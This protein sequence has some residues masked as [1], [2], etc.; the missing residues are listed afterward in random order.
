MNVHG[1]QGGEADFDAHARI[2]A[3]LDLL[4]AGP[5][6]EA[7]SRALLTGAAPEDVETL[8]P[9]A[10]ARL[11]EEAFAHL[12]A[13]PP[14]RHDVRV[15]NPEWPGA[16][17]ITVIEAANDDM[18]FLFDSVAGELADRNLELK[19]TSH[20][21][22]AVKRDASGAIES[23]SGDL[24]G[25]A[26]RGLPHESLIHLHIQPLES[27]EARAA[28]KQAL[29]RTLDDV[30][31]ATGDFIAMRDAV[32]GLAKAWPGAALPY[33]E[34][35]RD[36]AADFI[37]WLVGNNFIFLGVRRYRRAGDGLLEAETGLGVLRDPAVRE[38]AES[39]L[40]ADGAPAVPGDKPLLIAK[41]SLWS[42]VHRR[43]YMDFVGLTLHDADGAP[44][45]ELRII[46]LFTS[47][48]YT[49]SV[50]EIPYLRLKAEAVAARAGFERESHSGKALSTVLETYPRDDLFQ[51]DVDTLA[52]YALDILSLYD[53]PR[54]RVLPRPDLFGRF[55]SVLV[56]VPRERFDSALRERIGR[57]L[58]ATFDGRV[59]SFTPAFLADVPLTRVH[60][61]IGRSGGRVPAV[62]R[63]ELERAVADD[64]LSWSDR[65]RDALR[66][67][68]GAHD[69]LVLF[70]RY[71]SAFGAGYSAAYGV[72]TAVADI[73][74]LERL[75]ADRPIALDFYR[76]EDDLATRISLRLLS[77]GRPLP[78]SERVPMLENMGLKAINERTYR[79][80]PDRA[81]TSLAWIHDMT[82]ERCTGG[83]IEVSGAAERMEDL[84]T[85]VL[86]GEA[87]NDGFNALVLDTGL[88]WR[89]VA[90]ARALA[91]YLRQAGI[92]YSQDYLWATLVG[93]A[94]VAAHIVQLFHMRFDPRLDPAAQARAAREEPL[95]REIEAALAEVSSLDEDTIL[96]RFVNL[97]DAALRTT[98]YQV[99][100]DGRPKGAISIKY[101]SAKVEGLP[102]PRPLY[103]V[104]VYSPRVEGVHLRFGHVARGGLRWSDRPQDFRTEVLG[105]VKAQQV[106][107]AVIVPVGAK[108]GFVPKR[109]PSGGNR[110]AFMAEGIAAYKLF[111][112]SLLDITDN[113]KAGQL[114]YPPN[115]VRID[116]DDPYLVVAADKGTAT[117][118][119]T[120]NGISQE[121]GFWLDDAFASGG[122]VGYDHKA[123]GITARGAWEAVKRHFREID[124]D[125]Q[126]T[127]IQ[128]V[129]VGD[130]SGDVFGNGMLLSTVLKL[131]AAFDHRHIFLDPDP[132]PAAAFAERQRLFALP[133]S[134]WADYDAAL[135]SKGGGVFSRTAKSIPLS[136]EVRAVIGLEK[137]EATPNEVMNAILKAQVDL[138][139]FG[140][141]G[142]YVRAST[143]T[144]AQAGDRANDAIRIPAGDLRVKV[145]GEGANLGMTQRGRIEAARRGVRLNTDAIDN[146]AGVNTSD[147]EVNIKIALS[148]PVAEG[149]LSAP[150][151]AALLGTMTD[152]VAHLVL[153]NNYLQTLALSLAQRSGTEDM[154]F[155]QRLM[156]M[157]ELRGELDRAV[158]Y[159]P[160]DAE[161]QER[162]S[163]GEALT[164]PELAV[165]LAYAK[166]SL[167]AEMLT[168]D[169]PDDIYLADEL[170][171]YFP[172]ALQSRFPDAIQ[173]HR[174]RREIIATGLANAV[175]N[176]GGPATIAR[177]ADQS[178][179]DA[180]A[181]VR[182]FAA[183][184]DSFGLPALNAAIDALDS[185]IPGDMQLRLYAE[186]QN[187]SLARTIWF[188]RNVSLQSGIGPVVARYRT[189]IEALAEVLDDSLPE[190]W[191]A[192][193]DRKAAEFTDAG[194]PAPLAL[195]IAGLRPLAAGTDIALLSQTTGRSVPEAARTFFAAGLYFGVDSVL[196]AAGSILAPDYYDRL[197]MDRALGQ[198]E[199][200][201]R[202][203]SV[204]MLNGPA[205]GTEAVEAWVAGRRKEVERTRA[206]VQDIV[207]SGLTLSKLT[208]AAS[209]LSDIARA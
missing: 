176:Q 25:A 146:S 186:V 39:T 1:V 196:S 12:A 43:A 177:I 129:G 123:M 144:D 24:H 181:I 77:Y 52:T 149:V 58:A 93:H 82:L 138:L 59:A 152:E 46:G 42:R 156:Q 8:F 75:S 180:A 100:A 63:P 142:T 71:G 109:L 175:I 208:L 53:R 48:A 108:G 130:M 69:A 161:I 127:P 74:R 206:T 11:T 184:R 165:L 120:A 160:S 143:E 96:R 110:E 91:R 37:S 40:A 73:E 200:F 179:A 21:I 31:A 171:H 173:A 89:D 57:R 27:E 192:W 150:D 78:L 119:D 140:G 199:S 23:V 107:N 137:L 16:P 190:N 67:A 139:W 76:R 30:R 126:T 7:F 80:A 2:D 155:Q 54:V 65:L 151:R 9:D 38:F 5:V 99:E 168:T 4:K 88:A 159:L 98:F 66:A 44:A 102:L 3:A 204:E 72:Q 117:F 135:I 191:R 201:V 50:R 85:A 170:V 97:V 13:R 187:L 101:E 185:K 141:I 134:S 55:V 94:D 131:V 28:L 154:A 22:L 209:L 157:L 104:F 60:F 95:R 183:V 10:L 118:S 203:V 103:E 133:R 111:V 174:L 106:K 81:E 121:H 116:G 125:I 26:T 112:S 62:D 124:I 20:P 128:V 193:R 35:D 195:K 14:G 122:S 29:D 32:D 45:G 172:H 188:L 83:T 113:L 136:P 182:A 34:T 19:L 33:A 147:V 178:G 169:V 164:R 105:L 15:Y 70:E 47:T 198:I 84:L 115:V 163:R 18:A 61:T 167:Y 114:V 158:E 205:S 145:V 6:P 162:R 148:I 197:A 87:E 86:R 51:I 41:S 90:L 64:V 153:R 207:A 189:D 132:D 166:L 49:H 194:V 56:Y 202:Q 92:P 36:E 17:A 79:I 68:H